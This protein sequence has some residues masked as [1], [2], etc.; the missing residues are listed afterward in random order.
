[1]KVSIC[2]PTYNRYNLL[3]Q[4]LESIKSQT[5]KNYEVI[6]SNNNSSDKTNEIVTCA[7]YTIYHHGIS[8][9]WYNNWNFCKNKASGDITVICHDDDIYHKDYLSEIVNCFEKHNDVT[10]IH[11]SSFHFDNHI[12]TSIIRKQRVDPY[13]MNSSD[14]L[15][16]CSNKWCNINCPTV[17]VR[18]YIYKKIDFDNKYLSADYFMWFRV[19]R[20][21]GSICYIN[22]P[23]VYYRQ[24]DSV[25]TNIDNFK[26][27]KEYKEMYIKVFDHKISK[28][29]LIS[30]DKLL[31]YRIFYEFCLTKIFNF[32]YCKDFSRKFVMYDYKFY[33]S[34]LFKALYKK[35]LR[36]LH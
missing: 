8:L 3:L 33:T 36:Q 4:C 35:I 19:L 5:Y 10:L 17:A 1:M 27:I 16:E 6:I 21:G 32:S 25:K 18:T 31:S 13:I 2:I 26:A 34:S 29:V 24:H 23:L 11:T 22:K 28:Q 7:D 9:N 30:L 15:I 14:Y 12:S 20:R